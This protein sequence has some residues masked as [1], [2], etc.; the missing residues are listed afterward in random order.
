MANTDVPSGFTPYRHRSG[1]LIRSNPYKLASGYGTALFRGDACILSSGVI[2]KAADN[3]ATLLGVIEGFRYTASDGSFVLTD[4]WVASTTTL[5]SAD[6]EVLVYDD[7]AISYRCQSDT[8][9]AFVAATHTGGKYDLELDHA[10]ST[11]SGQSGMEVD[12]SDTG[13]GQFLV[14]GLIDEPGNAVGVN[15]KLEVQIAVPLLA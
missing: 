6:V 11:A 8:G 10:G 14:L 9:T 12:L 1:G 3:S 15:A 7:P 5:G 13:T 2:A 4:K